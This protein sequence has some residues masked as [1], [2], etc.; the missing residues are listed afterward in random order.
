MKT[1]AGTPF[2]LPPELVTGLPYTPKVDLWALG[3]MLYDL[4]F[5]R[6]PFADAGTFPELF[7]R[8]C[9]ADFTFPPG[10]GVSEQA[11]AFIRRLLDPDQATRP[12]A[13][14]ALRVPWILGAGAGAAGYHGREE[15]EGG[16][17][18][19]GTV[20]ARGTG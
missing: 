15:S 9:K 7:S 19:T 13:D 11:K 1:L 3:C 2:Y 5:G 18:W 14:E 20:G 4:L 16:W 17:K 6:A 10:S 8:I 12:G